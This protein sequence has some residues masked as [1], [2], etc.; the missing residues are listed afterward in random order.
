M[1]DTSASANPIARQTHQANRT[2]KAVDGKPVSRRPWKPVETHKY[3]N[4]RLA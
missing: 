4:N 1:A 3:A 2:R